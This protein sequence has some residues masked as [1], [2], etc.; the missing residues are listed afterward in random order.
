MAPAEIKR[1]PEALRP[2]ERC[3]DCHWLDAAP[4]PGLQGLGLDLGG[5]GAFCR[6]PDMQIATRA[7]ARC[8]HFE[9]L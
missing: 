1:L 4:K 7:S 2:R 9:T 5:K 6:H 3:Q 8:G